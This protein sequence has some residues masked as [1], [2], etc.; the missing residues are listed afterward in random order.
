MV[1]EHLMQAHDLH[2]CFERQLL[3]ASTLEQQLPALLLALVSFVRVDLQ[4]AD[5]ELERSLAFVVEQHL[6]AHPTAFSPV[7]LRLVFV[8]MNDPDIVLT[9]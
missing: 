5:Y 6:H 7:L 8:S 9:K 3:A 2:L 1:V 4:F